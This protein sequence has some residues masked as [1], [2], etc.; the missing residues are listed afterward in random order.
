MQGGSAGLCFY[1]RTVAME[2]SLWILNSML[3]GAG[4]A[5]DAFSVSLANGLHE[6][7]MKRGRMCAI[8]G[9]FAAFQTVMP[10]IGWFLVS[11]LMHVFRVVDP[12]IPWVAFGLLLLIGGS[13]LALRRKQK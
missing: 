9:T 11:M 8:A 13:L 7:G 10:L 3:L 2:G 6:S 5:M 12:Y 4:L 1:V